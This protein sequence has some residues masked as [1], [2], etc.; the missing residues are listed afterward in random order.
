MEFKHIEYFVETAKHK[1]ISKA[2]ENL[3]ISQQALS[4]CMKNPEAELSCNLFERTVKGSVLTEEGKL[5][6]HKFSPIVER[7]RHTS[8][9]SHAQG[10]AFQ[11][12]GAAQKLH[13]GCI[14][15]F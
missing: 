5:L 11:A 10:F 7:F 1:S 4:R 13:I 14:E 2:A 15:Y 9:G 3:F 6:Y 12:E 8:I